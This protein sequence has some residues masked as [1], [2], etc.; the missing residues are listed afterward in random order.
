[1]ARWRSLN[2]IDKLPFLYLE[3]QESMQYLGKTTSLVQEFKSAEDLLRKTPNF[4]EF[5]V[6]P[7][8]NNEFNKLYLL[9]ESTLS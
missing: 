9:P 4:W 5:Y 3:F 6:K 2:Y 7:K 1:M 8:I